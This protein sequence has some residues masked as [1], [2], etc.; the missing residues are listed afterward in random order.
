MEHSG[1]GRKLGRPVRPRRPGRQRTTNKGALKKT[2]RKGAYAPARK[3]AFQKR[4]APFVET[5]NQTDEILA[6]KNG[7]ID[8]SV[9]DGIRNPVVPL[10]ISNGVV[11]N[12]NELTML[13]V[14]TFFNMNKG[15][16]GSD[17]IG[18]SVYSRYL[19]ARLEFEIPSGA[20]AIQHPCNLYLIHGWVTA[21]KNNT[22]HTTTTVEAQTRQD[23]QDYVKNH[24]FEHFNQRR[25]R[26]WETHPWIKYKLHGC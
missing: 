18:S 21:P 9:K 4:R 19:Q 8:G 12:A 3:A 15:L 17:M 2:T 11:S 14:H 22:L 16:E 25:D 7:Q 23:L 20:K 5:K 13:P 1:T 26:D 24:V 6:G 10:E